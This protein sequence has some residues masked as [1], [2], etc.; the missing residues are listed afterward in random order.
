MPCVYTRIKGNVRLIIAVYVDDILVLSNNEEEKCNLKKE[1]MS[2]FDTKDLGKAKSILGIKI[3]REK[4]KIYLDQK[5]YIEKILSKYNMSD[6]KPVS[7]PF[8]VG[9]KLNRGQGCDD[10][11]YQQ[12]IGSLNFLAVCTRPDITYT[13][14]YLSRF[15]NCHE[16]EHSIAAKR[17]LRYL[18]GTI[19][20]C[21]KYQKSDSNIKGYAD[22][23]FAGD[24]DDRKSCTGFTFLMGDGA[25]TW[26]SKKQ[27]L[28]AMST[29][30]SEYIALSE[31]W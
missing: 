2:C 21:L 25:I 3:R 31:A 18:K 19:N 16:E 8:A 27:T 14:N 9:T 6:C 29:S 5:S 12:L 13:V 7:T 4:G 26:E 11:P 22:V 15:N 30:E 17:V 20:V 23:D 1:L 10:L 28:V 24:E